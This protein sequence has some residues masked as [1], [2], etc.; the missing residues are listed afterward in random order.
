M[1]SMDTEH[2]PDR[3]RP[4]AS[5]RIAMELRWCAV[6]LKEKSGSGLSLF[7][8]FYQMKSSSQTYYRLQSSQDQ[9]LLKYP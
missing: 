6:G 5:Y 1:Q 9:T 2:S 3:L 8:N 7:R 4:V